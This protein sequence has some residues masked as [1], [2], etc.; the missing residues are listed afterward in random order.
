MASR[1]SRW[2][3]V[4]VAGVV[5]VL[6][7]AAAWA[8]LHYRLIG[9][10][11]VALPSFTSPVIPKGTQVITVVAVDANGKPING[12]RQL[13]PSQDP[14]NVADVFGCAASPAAVADDIYSCAP[15]AAG[16]DVCWPAGPSAP[17]TLWCLDDP[18]SKGLRRVTSTDPLPH[19]LAP[20]TPAPFALL[21]DDGTQCRLRN[22]GAWGGRDDGLVGAYGCPNET[23]A[24]L[25]PVRPGG[26]ES[27]ID[28]SQA[29][30]TVKVGSLGSGEAHLP[31][32]QTR[33]V[34]T[35]WFAGS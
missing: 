5:A 16:A 22:G 15:N 1:S 18:W 35:A 26:G 33:T 13:P 25:V 32:P 10:P 14:G 3:G 2:I 20:P 23:P 27:A 8:L 21:L 17:K 28:R 30:W 29:L 4:A 11:D 7:V 12:Y 34:V 6:V 19:V 9:G 24:V 31:P